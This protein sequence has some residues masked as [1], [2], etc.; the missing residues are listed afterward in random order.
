MRNGGVQME[1]KGGERGDGQIRQGEEGLK[2][3]KMQQGGRE[4]GEKRCFI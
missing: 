4:D 1:R 2:C 3:M